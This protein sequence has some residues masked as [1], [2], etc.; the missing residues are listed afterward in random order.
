MKNKTP[1]LFL[2]IL[3]EKNY[4]VSLLYS[5]LIFTIFI[6]CNSIKSVGMEYAHKNLYSNFKIIKD[7]PNTKTYKTKFLKD[8][9]TFDFENFSTQLWPYWGDTLITQSGIDK[10]FKK[11]R[12]LLYISYQQSRKENFWGLNIFPNDFLS[13]LL[14]EWYSIHQCYKHN[15]LETCKHILNNKPDFVQSFLLNTNRPSK[16]SSSKVISPI[17]T[18]LLSEKLNLN[19]VK[20]IVSNSNFIINKDLP[21]ILDVFTKIRREPSSICEILEILFNH[22]QFDTNYINKSIKKE[23]VVNKKE[24]CYQ[25]YSKYI[26]ILMIFLKNFSLIYNYE[27]VLAELSVKTIILFLKNEVDLNHTINSLNGQSFFYT[28]S[29]QKMKDDPE[30]LLR[31]RFTF[32]ESINMYIEFGKRTSAYSTIINYYTMKFNI[33]KITDIHNLILYYIQPNYSQT[34]IRNIK[35]DSITYLI[36]NHCIY[37]ANVLLNKYKVYCNRCCK[38]I[39]SEKV[40]KCSECHYTY[41]CKKKCQRKDWKIGHKNECKII[42][43]CYKEVKP[44]VDNIFNI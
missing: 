29:R 6:S 1:R 30:V 18:L 22:P 24:K 41:Y 20:H 23:I 28:D 37:E 44:F 26:S 33:L 21:N 5:L 10:K 16:P 12:M 42:K 25:I 8:L 35:D 14:K 36:N 39:I 15:D 32:L 4:F 3:Q 17:E 31:S 27:K 7:Q 43:R 9:L 13:Q 11:W 38:R 2:K 19:F 34:S 40:K